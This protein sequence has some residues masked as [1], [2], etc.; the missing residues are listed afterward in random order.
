MIDQ[1]ILPTPWAQFQNFSTCVNG[2]RCYYTIIV[3]VLRPF[4]AKSN[5]SNSI[6]SRKTWFLLFLAILGTFLALLGPISE[7]CHMCE[8]CPVLPY[9]NR[10]RFRPFPAKS[11]DW[12]WI[13]G[14]KSMFLHLFL[15]FP[16]VSVRGSQVKKESKKFFA[17]FF[18][19]FSCL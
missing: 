2:G 19:F 15:F 16:T 14:S 18:W 4:L 13:R 17:F 8:C 7:F 1:S 10:K 12:N 11:N 9:N 3:I 5:D 6:N